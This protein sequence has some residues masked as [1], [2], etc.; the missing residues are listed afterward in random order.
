LKKIGKGY[1][2]GFGISHLSIDPPDFAV[3]IDADCRIQS[4]ALGRLRE[5]C[6]EL[7]RPVSSAPLIIA[8]ANVL[9]FG[10]AI[11]FAWLKFGRDILPAQ[12]FLSISA[13]RKFRLYGQMLLGRTAV[14]WVRNR[15][16]Q[17]EVMTFLSSQKQ[18]EPSRAAFA[19]AVLPS[20]SGC[21]WIGPGFG[22]IGPCE[23]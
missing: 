8:T 6:S 23:F 15:S 17:S 4:D 13:L 3:F 10:L 14:Q 7:Q 19:R 12:P 18:S 9:V 5:I 16:C 21:A 11:V 2:L 22:E 1:A 20:I